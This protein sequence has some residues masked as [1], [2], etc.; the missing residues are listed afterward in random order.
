[1]RG[2]VDMKH[3]CLS[4]SEDSCGMARCAA[5]KNTLLFQDQ[6]RESGGLWCHIRA[7]VVVTSSHWTE[8]WLVPSQWD[9]LFQLKLPAA[10][11]SVNPGIM[12]QRGGGA[13]CW[14]DQCCALGP[15]APPSPGSWGRCDATALREAESSQNSLNH[16]VPMEE[17]AADAQQMCHLTCLTS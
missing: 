2:R 9:Q 12:S 4:R 7:L 1:M 17:Q 5:Q 14:P 15:E 10:V 6:Q 13:S 16:H 11:I 3:E 8:R